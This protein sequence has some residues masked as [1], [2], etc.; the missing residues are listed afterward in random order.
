MCTVEESSGFTMHFSMPR[1]IGAACGELRLRYCRERDLLTRKESIETRKNWL[2]L[3][4]L[5]GIRGSRVYSVKTEVRATSWAASGVAAALAEL[6]ASRVWMAYN[7]MI[8]QKAWRDVVGAPRWLRKWSLRFALAIA[9]HLVKSNLKCMMIKLCPRGKIKKIETEMWNLK[10]RGTDVVAYSQR[11]Q[12]LALMCSRMFPEE[13][14]KIEKYIGG[15][16]DMIHAVFKGIKA[17]KACPCPPRCNN[18]KRVGHLAKDCRSRPA[19]ANNNNRNNNNNNQKGNGC[20]ECGGLMDKFRRNCP[21]LKNNDL[22]LSARMS[23]L[24]EGVVCGWNAG[25]TQTTSLRFL[26]HVIDSEGNSICGSATSE[27]IK[28]LDIPNLTTEI[29]I[30]FCSLCEYY[31]RFH[32][33]RSCAVHQSLTLPEGIAK[34]HRHT[35]D[36]SKRV[37]GAVL[38]PKPQKK[39]KELDTC[40]GDLRFGDHAR[41]P[42]I[43]ILYT[44]GFWKDV[45]SF[46]KSA[47]LVAQIVGTPKIPDGSGTNHYGF[48]LRKLPKTSQGYGL[49]FGRWSRGLGYTCLIIYD[50][51]PR[52]S[53]I[54]GRVTSVTL[55]GTN[56]DMSMVTIL[57][58]SGK[59]MRTIQ[60]LS[61]G[62]RIFKSRTKKKAKTKQNQ[63]RNG[64]DKVKGVRRRESITATIDGHSMTITDGSLRRHLK[65]DDQDGISSI[66]NSEI[67]EQLALMRYHT[68][69]D[70]LTFQK[71]A[72]SPQ[73]RDV[74]VAKC[75]N[76][77]FPPSKTT[78][79]SEEITNFSTKDLMSHLVELRIRFKDLLRACKFFATKKAAD[80]SSIIES[81]SKV[82]HSRSKAIVAKVSTSASTSGV[83]PDVAELKDLVRAYF[84]NKQTY[85]VPAYC[86]NIHFELSFA[87]LALLHMRK[88]CTVWSESFSEQQ[89]KILEL[90]KSPYY[91]ADP[92]VPLILGRPFL[93]T[94]RALI[95]VHG[96]KMTLRHDDQ[97]VTFKVGDT[98]HFSYNAIESVNKVDFLDIA[99]EEYSQEVLGFSEVLA[100]GTSTPYFE[101]IVDTTSST[102]TP[103]EGSDFILEEIEAELSDTSYKSGIDDAECDP[104]RDILL[105]EAILNSEPLPPLPN[106][107]DYF[108]GIRKELK[109]CEAKTD[110]TPIDETPEVELKDLPPHLEYAFLYTKRAIAWKLSDIKGIN[111][112]FCTHKILM[113]ED[114][115]PAVQHQRR[116]N[117]KIHDVIKK[118]V[119]KLLD[120]GLIY[121]ISDSPWV[122]PVH[123]V[124]KKG[125]F[126]HQLEK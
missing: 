4:L 119:E 54:S 50:R 19:N 82:R 71:G 12:Q 32:E 91:D 96:E 31:Q 37:L 14:D 38:M 79:S 44:S 88:V 42:Q 1:R 52:L 51:D 105:L 87:D 23:G 57:K 21:K 80:C 112:E 81:K 122:S 68:D 86:P 95:D 78:K 7:S 85:P 59:A 115:T 92:R 121:P 6:E 26:G 102:L 20:Y 90:T 30:Q 93:R 46:E 72:F 41:S 61:R 94:A 25:K 77:F 24:Y 22:W 99:C 108:L 84:C 69:S 13:I 53:P 118:E 60:N 98:K 100:N 64:K 34:F 83:S 107:A 75:I 104:E 89:D 33:A 66:P 62:E 28:A 35:G 17:G 16:P 2:G 56:L 58:Q 110:E 114:Y 76:Q 111:P 3:R 97:S 109:I 10:V 123:C 18:C 29:R 125:G 8:F 67:F 73:W 27:S 120:A 47:I 116:V 126:S 36:T 9:Q 63:A 106:Q 45:P 70:K 103:F 74:L 11:F 43:K 55:L 65:L 48:L 101:P 15:L 40:Y 39:R 124:P 117:P 5:M 49:P 113:E